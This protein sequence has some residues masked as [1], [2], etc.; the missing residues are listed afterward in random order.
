MT[1]LLRSLRAGRW[2]PAGSELTRAASEGP[3]PQLRE[4]LDRCAACAAEYDSLRAIS[5][6]LAE[7]PKSPLRAEAIDL[8]ANALLGATK[9]APTP[10]PSRSGHRLATWTLSAALGSVLVAGG[11]WLARYRPREPLAAQAAV[12][13]RAAIRAIGDARF[14]RVQFA[15]DETVRLDEGTL[16]LDVPVLGPTETFRVLTMD[17]E[18]RGRA[19]QFEASAIGGRLELVRVWSGRVEIRSSRFDVTVLERGDQWTRERPGSSQG[20]VDVDVDRSAGA[21][22]VPA[23]RPSRRGIAVVPPRAIALLGARPATSASPP[24]AAEQVRFDR[25]WALL[26]E[27]RAAD[28]AAAFAEAAQRARGTALEEDAMYWYAVALA[29]AGDAPGAERELS[30]FVERF[31]R[32]SHRGEATV[33]LGWMLFGRGQTARARMFFQR[34]ADDPSARVRQSALEG[35]QRSAP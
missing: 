27:G 7:L 24:A 26:R 18:I 20:D 6:E 28:A 9:E 3:R 33:A 16:Q 17:E 11:F 22:S 2:C 13:N 19:T 21:P 12:G 5:F 23:S 8:I 31:P 4:H 29:R 15:P 1:R 25:A 10:P 32:S 30:T 34:A 14:A 35:L